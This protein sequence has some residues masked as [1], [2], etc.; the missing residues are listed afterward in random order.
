MLE[1]GLCRIAAPQLTSV[2]VLPAGVWFQ[3]QGGDVWQFKP[4]AHCY[5]AASIDPLSILES[6]SLSFSFF[7]SL[8][9][10]KWALIPSPASGDL[11]PSPFKTLPFALPPFEP[12]VLTSRHTSKPA[13]LGRIHAWTSVFFCLSLEI[14]CQAAGSHPYLVSFW[15][16]LHVQKILWVP[17]DVTAVKRNFPGVFTMNKIAF[18]TKYIFIIIKHCYF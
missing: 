13:V 14:K 9:N 3:S 11:V 10:R 2:L 6:F 16:F 1:G 15:F 12:R 8:W 17:V 5:T 18:S 4:L 7:C